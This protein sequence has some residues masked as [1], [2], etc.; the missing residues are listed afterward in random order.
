M[1]SEDFEKQLIKTINMDRTNE[2]KC[3]KRFLSRLYFIIESYDNF[4]Y[5]APPWTTLCLIFNM[6]YCFLALPLVLFKYLF[7]WQNTWL[8]TNNLML[9]LMFYFGTILCT[10]VVF[11]IIITVHDDEKYKKMK[12]LAGYDFLNRLEEKRIKRPFVLEIVVFTLLFLIP[13]AVNVFIV[14]CLCLS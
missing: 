5:S 1:G 3:C 10:S 6:L 13:L 11:A 4:N 7:N 2:K 12:S 8:N 14:I 9:L